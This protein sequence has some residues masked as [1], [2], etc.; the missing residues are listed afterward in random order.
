MNIKIYLGL[1]M[2][3]LLLLSCASTSTQQ[4]R[5][6]WIDNAAAVY[7]EQD[8]LTAVGQ[9]GSRERAAK[10]ALANL[11]EI[12]VVNVR[13]ETNTLTRVSRQQSGLGVTAESSTTLQ[14][15]IQTE[16]Q[17]VISGA[18]IKDSWLSPSGEYYAL[19]LLNKRKAALSLT[20]SIL[21][22]DDSTA[23]LIDYSLN[24]A[25]N[26][27]SALNALRRARDLQ[28]TRAIANLK[29][30]QVSMS[31]IGNDISSA[32]I[33]KLIAEKLASLQ[34][35]VV[36][37]G[38]RHAQTIQSALAGLGVQ[39]AENADL[40]IYAD[41]DMVKPSFINGWYWLRGS[42]ELSVMENAK[43]ICRKRWPMK[44]S[45]KQEELLIPR[46]QDKLDAN[47]SNYLN[48]LLSDSVTL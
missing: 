36:V 6:Q 41:I 40:Q 17:Q 8:Y 12:F 7:L 16:T 26:V 34:V 5:P 25:P 30:K 38:A 27:I 15:D 45:A 47:I 31:G 48:E 13:A 23:D 22:M 42:Y 21:E 10:N 3:S 32:K 14:R 29:L 18:V 20:E 46:L 33:E 9:G 37:E 4:G 28:S 1:L 35:S 2:S 11:A 19:A 24:H 39:V 44:V 43:V